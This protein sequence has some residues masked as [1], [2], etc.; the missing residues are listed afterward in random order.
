MKRWEYYL[1][2]PEDFKKLPE[3]QQNQIMEDYERDME[4][5]YRG[6]GMED[7]GD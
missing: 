1:D 5:K 7:T 3:D 6:S 2:W 4:E